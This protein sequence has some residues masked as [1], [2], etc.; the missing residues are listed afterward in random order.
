MPVF[1]R[2]RH[3]TVVASNALARAVSPSFDVGINIPRYTFLHGI[4]DVVECDRGEIISQVAAVLRDSLLQH[5]PDAQ[6]QKIVGELSANSDDFSQ[7]WADDS[8]HADQSGTTTVNNAMVGTITLA[9]QQLHFPDDFELVLVVWRGV[10]E[11]SRRALAQLADII[12]GLPGSD[13]STG[14]H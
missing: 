10:D 4:G 7:K 14:S 8:R 9:Y 3:L 1:V 11:P 2:D 13:P 5:D 6:F 12:A